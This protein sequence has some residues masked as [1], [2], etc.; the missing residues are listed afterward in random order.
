MCGILRLY[1]TRAEVVRSYWPFSVIL[2]PGMAVELLSSYRKEGPAVLARAPRCAQSRGG[3]PQRII[4][5]FVQA[6]DS[7]LLM[8]TATITEGNRKL[9]IRV[10]GEKHQTTVRNNG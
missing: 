6:F 8:P 9:L 10:N 3:L 2:S 7:D 1:I 4:I 5:G